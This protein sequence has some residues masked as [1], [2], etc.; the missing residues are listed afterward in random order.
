MVTDQA[1]QPLDRQP[2]LPRVGRQ[3]SGTPSQAQINIQTSRNPTTKEDVSTGRHG[4]RITVTDDG[5]DAQGPGTTEPD[6][7]QPWHTYKALNGERAD[8]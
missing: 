2:N 8:S 6:V 1:V 4:A 7:D 5:T 3:E